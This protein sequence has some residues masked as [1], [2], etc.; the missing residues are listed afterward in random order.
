MKGSI[1]NVWVSA[2]EQ[3]MKR[4]SDY[5]RDDARASEHVSNASLATALTYV[6]GRPD[7]YIGPAVG[8][9]VPEGYVGVYCRK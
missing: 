5:Y 3:I 9:V 4:Q 2:Q 8:G 6:A 1:H 7:H